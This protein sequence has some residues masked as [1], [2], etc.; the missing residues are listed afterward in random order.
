MVFALNLGHVVLIFVNEFMSQFLLLTTS[1]TFFWVKIVDVTKSAC[2]EDFLILILFSNFY[3][4]LCKCDEI[5]SIPKALKFS[6]MHQ[7]GWLM[8]ITCGKPLGA[9]QN[10]M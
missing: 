2:E 4:H 9:H 10:P 8:L 1:I 3:I 7:I 6:T 5:R